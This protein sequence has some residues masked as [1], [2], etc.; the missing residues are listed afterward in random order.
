M[1][2]KDGTKQH[3]ICG[4]F[5]VFHIKF[6]NNYK[7]NQLTPFENELEKNDFDDCISIRI[8]ATNIISLCVYV[9]VCW[10]LFCC[11]PHCICHHVIFLVRA[12]N[13]VPFRQ[14]QP[15]SVADICVIPVFMWPEIRAE[16]TYVVTQTQTHAHMRHQINNS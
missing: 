1:F 13:A 7:P 2:Q 6:V 9:S 8:V 4:Y 3:Q 5:G 10:M 11:F 14:W 16:S 15:M 12:Q